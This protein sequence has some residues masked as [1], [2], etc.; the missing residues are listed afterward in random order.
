MA[1]PPPMADEVAFRAQMGVA[2]ERAKTALGL[3]AASVGAPTWTRGSELP[4]MP[5]L[6]ALM[7]D[8][9]K[10]MSPQRR[11]AMAVRFVKIGDSWMI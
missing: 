6:D 3:V 8:I 2:I 1:M 10:L 5:E 9:D 11:A 4:H 7:G